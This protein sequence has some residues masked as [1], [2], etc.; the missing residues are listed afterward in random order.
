MSRSRSRS[1]SKDE[2]R[3]RDSHSHHHHHHHHYHHGSSSRDYSLE[4]RSK[5]SEERHKETPKREEPHLTVSIPP[6]DKVPELKKEKSEEMSPRFPL[7]FDHL[8]LPF[9]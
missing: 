6:V 7:Y 4:R 5:S 8:N 3:G 9:D 1:R 2:E